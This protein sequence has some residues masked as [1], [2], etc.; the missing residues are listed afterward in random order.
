M[1]WPT[2]GKSC[3]G[4]STAARTQTGIWKPL[5]C[6]PALR[7]G[8]SEFVIHSYLQE[9]SSELQ[10]LNP[11]SL[12]EGLGGPGEQAACTEFSWRLQQPWDQQ[13]QA[14][15]P[16]H[17]Q[18]QRPFLRAQA[19]ATHIPLS[20]LLPQ[21]ATKR[22]FPERKPSCLAPRESKNALILRGNNK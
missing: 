3:P 20:L 18:S 15:E 22:P 8:N 21:A 12:V 5:R 2:R 7:F 6:S 17:L 11:V 14:R 10:Q 19:D 13:E 1:T 16:I 9:Y 4:G